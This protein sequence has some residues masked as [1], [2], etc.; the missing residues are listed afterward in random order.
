MSVGSVLGSLEKTDLGHGERILVAALQSVKILYSDIDSIEI[1][2][3]NKDEW[4][5]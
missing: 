4:R 1:M 5:P 2:I 3:T